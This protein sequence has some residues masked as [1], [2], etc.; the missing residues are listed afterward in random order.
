MK[1]L[2]QVAP[3]SDRY[4]GVEVEMMAGSARAKDLLVEHVS[5]DIKRVSTGGRWCRHTTHSPLSAAAL[6]VRRRGA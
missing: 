3:T 2:L 6:H 1:A 5:R 4:D